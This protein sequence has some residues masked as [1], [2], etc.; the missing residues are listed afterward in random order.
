MPS[1]DRALSAAIAASFNSPLRT[2]FRLA[3]LIADCVRVGDLSPVI[4]CARQFPIAHEPNRP[5]MEKGHAV[6][7]ALLLEV[8]AAI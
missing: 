7:H 6:S 3:A 8:K 1:N 2:L 4:R 5:E